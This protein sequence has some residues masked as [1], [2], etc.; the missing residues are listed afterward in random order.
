MGLCGQCA[1]CY[2]GRYCRKIY[3]DVPYFSERSCYTT[4]DEFRLL[5]AQEVTK[6]E[7]NTHELIKDTN[8][9][10]SN[11]NTKVCSRCGKEL[12]I[13]EFPK[14][15]RAKDGHLSMCRSCKGEIMKNAAQKSASVK[16]DPFGS[17]SS[18]SQSKSLR[19][20][21]PQE[22]V[23]HLRVNGWEVTCTKTITL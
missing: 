11:A 6:D 17:D 21:T 7:Y 8:K 4:Q 10:E 16:F 14:N 15:F 19:D 12:P 9:M 1:W 2:D 22:L 20:Y 5:F 23:D 18:V 3:K 13:E